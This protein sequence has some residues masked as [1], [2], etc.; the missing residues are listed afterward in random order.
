M[1]YAK[2]ISHS[3]ALKMIINE[4]EQLMLLHETISV[5]HALGRVIATDVRAPIDVP[6]FDCSRMD[7]YAIN[8]QQLQSQ[9][10]EE[11]SEHDYVIGVGSPIHAQEQLTE[12][13]CA[14]KALPIMTGGMLPTDATA[15]LIKEH[16]T[17]KD[18]QLLFTNCPKNGAYIRRRGSDLKAGQVVIKAHTKLCAASLGLLSSLGLASVQVLKQPKVALM[19]TG[20]ELV[21]PGKTCKLGQVFDANAIMLQQMLIQ[22]GCHVTL[23][24]PLKDSIPV[25]NKRLNQ[26]KAEK[27]QMIISVGG[28]SMG[29]KDC[30]TQSLALHGD[31]IFHKIKVKP[32]FPML[33]GRLNDALFYGLP[34]NPV[35]AYTTLCQYAFPAIKTL[36]NQVKQL[37]SVRAKLNHEIKN[38]H[39]RREYLR[40]FYDVDSGG[41]AQVSVCG[42][43][44]SSRIGSLAQANCFI[45]INEAQHDLRAGDDVQIQPFTQFQC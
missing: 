32:G 41:M 28:V 43:Q 12:S 22:M 21:A 26:L 8:L 30:M 36:L 40:G 17:I 37:S 3:Q 34:G 38:D 25:V 45:V 23:L 20:D 39:M 42:G 13:L 31:M 33:F 44:Q 7:G 14:G 4:A 11:N 18:G 1:T 19:M 5:E 29:D 2:S 24:N 10:K 16:A 27:Y 9:A 15:I 35:S 6:A